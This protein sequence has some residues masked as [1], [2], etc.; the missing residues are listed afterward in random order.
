MHTVGNFPL[1]FEEIGAAVFYQNEWTIVTRIP[2]TDFSQAIKSSEEC[3]KELTKIWCLLNDYGEIDAGIQA[4][5]NQTC[6]IAAQFVASIKR[7]TA[8]LNQV[9]ARVRHARELTSVGRFLKWAFGTMDKNDAQYIYRKL[10]LLSNTT[11]RS[12][13]IHDRQITLLKAS[14]Q[15]LS[16]PILHLQTNVNTVKGQINHQTEY[17]NTTVSQQNMDVYWLKYEMRAQSLNNRLQA[18]MTAI[19]HYV[20]KESMIVSALYHN[21]LPTGILSDDIL[22]ELYRNISTM[23]QTH[24]GFGSGSRVNLI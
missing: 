12:L 4:N 2:R 11:G 20:N 19:G 9:F 16:R 3:L 23:V 22:S 13:T 24:S 5:C 14:H 7:Q 1:F 10:K 6:E 15:D 8:E 21:K 18:L 17:L